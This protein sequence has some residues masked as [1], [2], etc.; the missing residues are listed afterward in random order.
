MLGC[1]VF[2]PPYEKVYFA[3]ACLF[4]FVVVF[5][6]VLLFLPCVVLLDSF[7]FYI[8]DCDQESLELRNLYHLAQKVFNLATPGYT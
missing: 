4:F 5:L 3:P 7:F 8:V 6:F 1:H 2:I